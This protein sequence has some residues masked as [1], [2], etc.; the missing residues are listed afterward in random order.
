LQRLSAE[1]G[2]RNAIASA[3][4]TVAV[5]RNE[6]LTIRTS[7]RHTNGITANMDKILPSVVEVKRGTGTGTGFAIDARGYFLT[8]NHV[9]GNAEIV[10]LRF[11]DG[12]ETDARV[13]RRD[14]L[15]DIAL[16]KIERSGLRPLA[17]RF[18]KLTLTEKVFAIGNPLGLSQTVTDGI[19][20]AYRQRPND[21]QDYI[22][23]SVN[24]TFGNSGGPLLDANGNVVGVSVAVMGGGTLG[25][26]F[27]IPIESALQHLDLKLVN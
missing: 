5:S 17:V 12:Q 4:P 26:N 25:L 23:A 1:P 6:T 19:V 14:A 8:N 10:T 21:G 16:L 18:G 13:L 3:S 9:V 24:V 15:R 11:N 27:F 2:F 22:Q 20:S 7:P